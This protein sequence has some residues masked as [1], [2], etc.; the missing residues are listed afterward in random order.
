MTAV[1]KIFCFGHG[2]VAERLSR[3]LLSQGWAVCSTTTSPEK[4]ARLQKSGIECFLFDR[5]RTINDP[6]EVFGG[7]THVLLSIPPDSEG[8]PV[9]EVH[10]MD[11]AKIKS[12]E[13]AGYLSATTVYG[14]HDGNWIDESMPPSP[15]SR[16][17]SLRRKAEEQWESLYMDEGFPLHTFR[18]AGIYGPGRSAIDS[19]RAG[20][21]RCIDKP[22]HVFN[23]IHVDDISQ[24]LQASIAK[25]Y[26]GAIYN[27][28]DDVPSPSHEVITYACQLVGIAPPPVT[29]FH[30]AEMAPIVRSF[31][32]DN[33]RI[34]NDRI[35]QELGVVLRYPDYR[36]GLESCLE[37]STDIPPA[38]PENL[39]A[40]TS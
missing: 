8:D 19:V 10:G 39:T 30:L 22:N 36:C 33:K 11:I 23:R 13:W 6:Y 4:Q 37:S 1:K 2:Y 27:L 40:R 15:D 28:A 25:P 5:N 32:K 26:P 31:Y 34:R 24:V 35:K 29:P 14:N 17:G 18:I 16:R 7:V 21:A 3:N 12:L 38:E 9:F 20:N